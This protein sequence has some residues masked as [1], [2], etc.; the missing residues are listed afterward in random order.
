VVSV[1][2][3]YGRIQIANKMGFQQQQKC[4]CIVPKVPYQATLLNTSTLLKSV[5][6]R[7]LLIRLLRL[8]VV[9]ILLSKQ[10]FLKGIRTSGN[11]WGLVIQ[12][13]K[14]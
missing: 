2:N 13:K 5:T 11:N 7:R 10:W 3:P 4:Y 9:R 8:A 14:K 12:T 1:T 6:E